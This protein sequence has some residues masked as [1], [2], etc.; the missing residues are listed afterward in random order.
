VK[1]DVLVQKHKGCCKTF[2]IKQLKRHIFIIWYLKM[3]KNGSTSYLLSEL[4]SSSFSSSICSH[5]ESTIS[6]MRPTGSKPY[7]WQ[8]VFHMCG[9]NYTN[10]GPELGLSGV[11]CFRSGWRAQIIFF[12]APNS[13]FLRFRQI[14]LEKELNSSGISLLEGR[15]TLYM[16]YCRFSSF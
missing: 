4:K 6:P 5:L 13:Y 3:V 2:Q 16:K 11:C 10:L 15:E 12:Y 9:Q 8:A 1:S 14:S 7:L